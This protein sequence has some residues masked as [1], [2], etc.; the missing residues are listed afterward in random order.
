MLRKLDKILFV[1]GLILIIIGLVGSLI[2]G[3]FKPKTVNIPAK[4]GEKIQ[5]TR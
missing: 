5:N 4:S 3:M 2:L 1:G